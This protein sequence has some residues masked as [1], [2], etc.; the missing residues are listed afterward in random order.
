MTASTW[1]SATSTGYY[2]RSLRPHAL[3]DYGAQA[4]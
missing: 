3:L 2:L 4:R 1:G